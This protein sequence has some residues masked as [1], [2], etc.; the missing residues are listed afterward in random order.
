MS[1]ACHG[2]ELSGY[3]TAAYAMYTTVIPSTVANYFTQAGAADTKIIGVTMN[4]TFAAGDPVTI[5]L[6]EA[7]TNI[8]VSNET[9][10]RGDWVECLAS[11]KIGSGSGATDFVALSAGGSG[12]YI[13]FVGVRD[14][15]V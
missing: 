15:I 6:F 5:R 14:M 2:R 12:E 7:G 9:V 11:G 10:A 3:A 4:E 1:A 8:A 13:E